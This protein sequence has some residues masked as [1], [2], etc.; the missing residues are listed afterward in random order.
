MYSSQPGGRLSYING[1]ETDEEEQQ[2]HT[3]NEV[4]A[5]SPSRVAEYLEDHGVEKQHCDIFREQEISGEVL[6]HM[7]QSAVFIK[8]FELGSVGRRL[9]TWQKVKALQDEVRSAA[10][11][12]VPR[13]VSDYSAAGDDSM[14]D[15][16]RTPSA[17]NTARSAGAMTGSPVPINFNDRGTVSQMQPPSS[18]PYTSAL[19]TSAPDTSRL[20]SSVRPSAASIR[21]LNHSRRH[22]SVGSIDSAA[23]P[24]FTRFSHQKQSSISA[25]AAA[26]AAARRRSSAQEQPPGSSPSLYDNSSAAHYGFGDP[27]SPADFDR[28]YF[29]GNEIEDRH[30]RDVLHKR[31]SPMH[32]RNTSAVTDSARH[33]SHFKTTGRMASVESMREPVSPILSP[34]SGHFP[35]N[36][37]SGSRTV[38]SPQ[39]AG[40]P[41][42]ALQGPT[43]PIVTKLEYGQ[44]SMLADSDASSVNPSPS[45]A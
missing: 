44:S 4:M 38:S 12:N 13:S 33:S 5:W 25:I 8:E 20:E 24:S 1:Q 10:A 35:F 17:P 42:S 14:S 45:P 30:R 32:S 9:K 18:A 15:M 19:Q 28:G 11:P 31:S 27:S 40:K 41:I 7:E 39:F 34:A 21:S 37:N 3:E 6:L 2:L 22:S 36:R 43:S 29:S 26:T 23:A 16:A